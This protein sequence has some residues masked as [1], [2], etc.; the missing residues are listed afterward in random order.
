MA[1]K[2]Y[3]K[4]QQTKLKYTVIGFLLCLGLIASVL[5]M[6]A[7]ID[8]DKLYQIIG[9]NQGGTATQKSDLEVHFIDVDQGDAVLI[10][11]KEHNILIDAGENDQAQKVIAYIK[12][13]KIKTL[14]LVIGTHPHSDHIGGLDKVIDT[15][16]VK[17]VM[18]PKIPS[19]LVPTTKTY[20]DLLQSIKRKNLKIQTPDVGQQYSFK[21]GKLT[22]LGPGK[23]NYNN[24]ND[25]SIS[26]HLQTGQKSFLFSGDAEKIAE[27]DMIASGLNL[28]ANVFKG[29]HHGSNTS[30]SQEFL[31][32]IRPNIIVISVGKGNKYGHPHTEAIQ[33]YKTIGAQ[34][35][36]TDIHGTIVIGINGKGLDE[37]IE[38]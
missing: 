19:K 23:S 17:Q 3:T 35:Y 5:V 15:F 24:L 30:N 20:E 2:K 14:D 33:R 38:Q 12:K 18:L 6:T 21:S 8:I 7:Q 25:F 1:K 31:K 10:T 11:S 36:R 16:E 29:A 28:K 4:A 26:V 9:L 27:Q 37:R 32:K 22:F 34:I 13:Q